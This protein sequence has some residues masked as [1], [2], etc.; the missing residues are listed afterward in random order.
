MNR[1]RTL[2]D[3]KRRVLSLAED[4][5][6]APR[7][8][9]AVTVAGAPGIAEMRILLSQYRA[10]GFI[11]EYD[12]FLATKLAYVLCGGDIDAEFKVTE[13]HLLDLEREVFLSLLG[14]EKTLERISHML[15]T[16]KPLRN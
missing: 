12:E 8:R 9:D 10:G 3:A 14:E 11:S 7:E 1:D 5:Y 6:C 4:G 15:K 16:G 2:G 13:Q